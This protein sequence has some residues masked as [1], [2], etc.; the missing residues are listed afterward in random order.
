MASESAAAQF[1]YHVAEEGLGEDDDTRYDY[2]R[3]QTPL[4]QYEFI[5]CKRAI[6]RDSFLQK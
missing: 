5:I 3:C 2:E 6:W 4:Y 1:T